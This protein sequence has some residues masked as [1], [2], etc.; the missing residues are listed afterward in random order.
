MRQRAWKI[1]TGR[2]SNNKIFELL[3]PGSDPAHPLNQM[4]L[5]QSSA[6]ACSGKPSARRFQLGSNTL[7]LLIGR[8]MCCDRD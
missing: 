8:W 6:V 2:P 5:T 4:R 7:V 1:E 3:R